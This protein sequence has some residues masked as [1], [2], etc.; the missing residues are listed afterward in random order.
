MSFSQFWGTAGSTFDPSS[1]ILK[2]CSSLVVILQ[3]TLHACS[4][5]W[6]QELQ[7]CFESK[8]TEML[9]TVLL[10]MDRDEAE[11]QLKRCIDSG[12]WVPNAKDAEE[13]EGQEGSTEDDQSNVPL[14]EQ[15]D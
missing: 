13:Q 3:A 5:I 7:D 4:L 6:F 1:T 2:T 9:Q 10:A 12:L 8:D 15:V 11:K 14:C